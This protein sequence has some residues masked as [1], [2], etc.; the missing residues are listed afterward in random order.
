MFVGCYACCCC[1]AD[2]TSEGEDDG[3]AGGDEGQG[4]QQGDAGTAVTAEDAKA[5]A[6]LGFE[7]PVCECVYGSMLGLK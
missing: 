1:K 3:T 5:T 6:K 4:K 2:F 7:A